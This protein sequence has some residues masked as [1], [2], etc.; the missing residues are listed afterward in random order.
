MSNSQRSN[1]KKLNLQVLKIKRAAF[2][3]LGLTFF[4][5]PGQ[6]YY[7][8]VSNLPRPALTQPI[9]FI[10]PWTSAYPINTT[11]VN[12]PYLTTRSAVVVDQSSGVVLSA[13]N[14]NVK[15]LPASTVKIMT[16]LVV[17]DYY[18][19]DQILVV[20]SVNDLGQNMKLVSG[21][22]I[23]VRNLFSGLLV[24]SANDAAQVLAQNYPGGQSVF[25]KAM[26]EKAQQLHLENTYFSNPIGLDSDEKGNLLADYSYT[27]ALDLA[28][29][30]AW[31]LKNPVFSQTVAIKKII[32][33][34]V[35][36]QISHELYNLN[37]LLGE[38]EGVKGIKTGWT[39]EAG[40][41][42]VTYVERE[43]KGIV[44]VVLGSQNRFGDTEKLIDWAF[45]NFHWENL[46]PHQGGAGLI[47]PS[48]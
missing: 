4:L 8:T 6:N 46:T 34:D 20:G 25:V 39:E 18:S 32:V 2:F 24:S 40:E 27:T 14:E 7:L 10:L 1:R 42:L 16:G 41:C 9:D 36:G 31:A 17:L 12:P 38:M 33:T 30:A 37:E 45:S 15:L 3:C 13:K 5:F 29:L 47:A 28:R 48:I 11:G 35:G 44:T 19:L 26:N 43:G 21:E 22:K 23:S